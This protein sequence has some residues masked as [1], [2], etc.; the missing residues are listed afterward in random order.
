MLYT[1]K[2][3]SWSVGA[4]SSVPNKNLSGYLFIRSAVALMVSGV[5][6]IYFATSS[7]EISMQTCFREGS[8]RAVSMIAI[9]SVTG[10]T[11]LPTPQC[12]QIIVVFGC[13]RNN[14]PN[15]FAW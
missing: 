12:A 15:C 14:A 1:F 6:T 9:W 7:H 8:E 13:L 2:Y 5:A 11:I 4:T 10:R 3:L